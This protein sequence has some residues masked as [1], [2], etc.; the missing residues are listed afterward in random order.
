ISHEY[1]FHT[2]PIDQ[3]VDAFN[4]YLIGD[5]DISV[6]MEVNGDTHILRA[7][8]GDILKDILGRQPRKYELDCWFT[9]LDFD[10]AGVLGIEEY[11]KGVQRLMAFSEGTSVPTTFTSYDTQ[12]VEWIHHSRVGYEP[13]QTL[14]APLT[15]SQEDAEPSACLDDGREAKEEERDAL[16]VAKALL[17][18]KISD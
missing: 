11:L 2:L 3:Y 12:R 8:L 9:H 6:V 4:K 10:R 7:K 17:R 13:Q 15:T 1:I 5:S 14:R 18:R 16:G